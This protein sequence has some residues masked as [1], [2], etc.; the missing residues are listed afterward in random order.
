ML[1]HLKKYYCGCKQLGEFAMK[2]LQGTTGLSLVTLLL[3]SCTSNSNVSQAPQPKPSTEAVPVASNPSIA[4]PVVKASPQG[5]ILPINPITLPLSKGRVDP[6]GSV[7]VSPI[8][9]SV[10]TETTQAIKPQAT[11]ERDTKPQ[12]T[13]DKNSKTQNSE[14]RTKTL[15]ESQTII[16]NS[17][18]RPTPSTDLARA[19]Q[20]NG[21]MQI[22]GRLSAIVKEP[23][24]MI[25]RSVSEGDYLSEGAVLVKRI[26][27]NNN[28]EP[29]VILEENG[30]E[31]VKPVST[32][33]KPFAAT[34]R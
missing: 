31:V 12:L 34:V 25:S 23:D 28:E 13:K 5:L 30:I 16:K 8:K 27:F 26:Q 6:F 15:P 32:T 10:P 2:K 19:V 21:V 9:L 7:A 3:V 22:E 14:I 33:T 17:P 18:V 29:T 4:S 20:V 1:N 11:K 24:E